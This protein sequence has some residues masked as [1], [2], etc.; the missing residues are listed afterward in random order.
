MLQS[1]YLLFMKR[2]DA[3]YRQPNMAEIKDIP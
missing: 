1:N 2:M 3:F